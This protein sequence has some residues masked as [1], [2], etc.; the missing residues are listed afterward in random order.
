MLASLTRLCPPARFYFI[1][2]IISYIIMLFQSLGKDKIYCLG[3]L[4][5]SKENSIYLFVFQAV[6]ILFWTWLLNVICKGGGTMFSWL[7]VLLPFI[8]FFILIALSLLA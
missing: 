2:S 6:Y 4:G 7:L 3:L 1:L 8:L 5:C